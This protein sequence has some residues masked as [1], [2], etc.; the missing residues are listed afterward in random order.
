VKS[1]VSEQ[2]NKWQ[3]IGVCCIVCQ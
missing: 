2:V 3:L 1:G